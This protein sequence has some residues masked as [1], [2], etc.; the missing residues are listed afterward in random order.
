MIEGSFPP[1]PHRP[2]D[3]DPMARLGSGC[4]PALLFQTGKLLQVPEP[5]LLVHAGVQGQGHDVQG[6]QEPRQAFDAGDT[7]GEHQ[8]AAWMLHQEVVQIQV[9]LVILTMDL[10]LCQRLYRGLISCEVNDLGLA[11]HANLL[12]KEVKLGSFVNFLSVLL[13]EDSSGSLMYQGQCGRK[14]KS[15]SLWVVLGITEHL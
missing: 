10:A 4:R 11:P 6:F 5:L 15:L 13:V 8:G 1:S 14:H 12:H 2:S 7:V 9:F 3:L